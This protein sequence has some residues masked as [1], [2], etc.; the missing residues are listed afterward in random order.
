M[1]GY[2]VIEA[3]RALLGAVKAP[4][5]EVKST[6]GDE[7]EEYRSL[8]GKK[9]STK[10]LEERH[11]RE[12]TAREREGVSEILGVAQSWLRDCLA[13]S[14]GAG[15]YVGNTDVAD[16]MEEVASVITPAAA[17]TALEAVDTARKRISYNVSPQ[18]A[19]EVMLFDIQE[20]L[21]CPR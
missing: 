12:L 19:I 1:D 4:L 8:L 9:V 21:R 15:V 18:L 14:Q 11:K 17:L 6:Q 10:P 7:I 5:D 2:D 20:V 13:V 16:A 3:A